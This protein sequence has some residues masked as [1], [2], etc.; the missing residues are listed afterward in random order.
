[1]TSTLADE[2]AENGAAQSGEAEKISA[3]INQVI[4]QTRGVA[5]GLFPVRLEETGLVVALEELAANAGELFKINCRFV[6]ENPP[7]VV[8]NAVALHLYYIVL[9]AVANAA[10]HGG[11]TTVVITLEPMGDRYLLRVRDDGAGFSPSANGQTGMGLRIMH[12]RARV[13]AATLNLQSQPGSGTVVSCLFLPVSRE[14]VVPP[15]AGKEKVARTDQ[16][17]K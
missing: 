11:A 15:P 1:M 6:S 2:L 16:V 13:I 8:D 5:R 3:M 14:T 7:A 17:P 10:K 4:E 12:Y 9:E